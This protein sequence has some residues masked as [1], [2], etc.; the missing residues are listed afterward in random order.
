MGRLYIPLVVLLMGSAV[1]LFYRISELPEPDTELR[2]AAS[3]LSNYNARL[4]R[5]FRL[6]VMRSAENSSLSSRAQEAVAEV[7][8]TLSNLDAVA[9]TLD[10]LSSGIVECVKCADWIQFRYDLLYDDSAAFARSREAW[11]DSLHK[12]N[13]THTPAL[14][15]LA[16]E[17]LRTQTYE[18]LSL[19]VSYLAAV[20]D[21]MT[22]KF[23]V[24]YPPVRGNWKK[25]EIAFSTPPVMELGEPYRLVVRISK[26]FANTL[27]GQLPDPGSATVDS[28]WVGDIMIVRLLGENFKIVSF[29]EEEQGVLDGEYT[30]WEFEVTPLKSGDQ[31]IQVKAGI[32]YP[33]PG[34]GPARKF[35]PVY[36]RT[37]AVEVSVWNRAA[38]FATER[39]EFLISTLLIPLGTWSLGRFRRKK[40]AQ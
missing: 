22:V 37:V 40:A 20:S 17:N 28:L 10:T 9:A 38:A 16:T 33:V 32:V 30:Q 2:D 23:D 1:F 35:F 18:L 31:D 13:A 24:G 21:A 5:D 26:E 39:W 7:K 29:D 25:G 11:L 8:R 12:V 34:L 4:D 15:T 3:W 27:M 19:Y 36:A 6:E 14:R